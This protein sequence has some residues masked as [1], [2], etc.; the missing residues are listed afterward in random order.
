MRL[1]FLDFDGVLNSDSFW[2]QGRHLGPDGKERAFPFS[3][4]DSNAVQLLN[5][6]VKETGAKVVFTTTWRESWG[7]EPLHKLLIQMGFTGDTIGMTPVIKDVCRGE[8]IMAFIRAH[9]E[10]LGPW[11]EYKDY[12]ILDDDNDMLLYQRNHCHIINRKYGLTEQCVADVTY[13]LTSPEKTVLE[14]C[15][16]GSRVYNKIQEEIRNERR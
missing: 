7:Y 2:S 12:V 14:R 6:I 1:C 4:L 5:R 10:I 15:L 13:L 16:P 11:Y 8:E 9:K 3:H